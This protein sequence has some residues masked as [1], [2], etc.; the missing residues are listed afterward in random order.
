MSDID[1]LALLYEYTTIQ[2]LDESM[3]KAQFWDFYAVFANGLEKIDGVDID[4]IVD[5]IWNSIVTDY[6]AMVYNRLIFPGIIAASGIKEQEVDFKTRGPSG[7]FAGYG[8]ATMDRIDP[9]I[10]H[11]VIGNGHVDRD[12]KL[13]PEIMEGISWYLQSPKFK[14][15]DNY[16]HMSEEE[17]EASGYLGSVG[18]FTSADGTWRRIASGLYSEYQKKNQSTKTKALS[19]DKMLAWSHHNESLADNI[20]RWLPMALDMRANANLNDII[21]HCSPTIRDALKSAAHGMARTSFGDVDRIEA[22]LN[23][24]PHVSRVVRNGNHFVIDR[25]T[26]RTFRTREQMKDGKGPWRQWRSTAEFEVTPD[27]LQ[28]KDGK[29]IPFLQPRTNGSKYAQSL[30]TMISHLPVELGDEYEL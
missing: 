13:V 29:L 4:H 10:K 12:P 22:A 30:R 25:R 7:A 28:P 5:E 9:K 21:A 11:L 24:D 19:V 26:Y 2:Q 16:K 17:V 23:R 20:A 18:Y 8:D 15:P 27:G 14:K 1:K 3:T 6:A